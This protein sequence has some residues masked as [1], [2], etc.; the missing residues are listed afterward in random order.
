MI[1]AAALSSGRLTLLA[2]LTTAVSTLVIL[3]KTITCN[4]ALALTLT[5]VVL[6]IWQHNKLQGAIAAVIF[7]LVKAAFV[8]VAFAVDYAVV[9]RGGFD[10]L[11]VTP[12]ILLA[13]L[14]LWQ[15]YSDV[16]RDRLFLR[17][18]TRILMGLFCLIGALSIFNP[19]NLW[20]N[21][22]AGFERV[23]LPNMMVFFLFAS[24]VR[25]RGSWESIVKT[26]LILGLISCA[27]AV[28]QFSLGAYPWETDWLR[29]VAFRDNVQGVTVG[30]RG[31]ELRLF[32]IFFGY[33][34][35]TFTNVIIFA[36]ALACGGAWS[37]GWRRLRVVYILL[38]I[39]VLALSLERMPLL[40]SLI[41]S[42]AVLYLRSSGLKR[43]IMLVTTAAAALAIVVALNTAEPV[44]R[45]T[46][47][48]KFVRLAEMAN[49]LSVS[50]LR[51]RIDRNWMPT[52]E[53]VQSNP[54]GVGI[55]YGSQTLATESVKDGGIWMGPH[56]ELLQKALETGIP[57]AIVFVLLLA[58]ILRDGVRGLRG[59]NSGRYAA[60]M[61]ATTVAFWICG[62]VNLPFVGGAGMVYWALAGSLLAANGLRG[63]TPLR[64]NI[65][66]VA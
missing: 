6:T 63:N 12:A 51:D 16:A 20:F 45:D 47:L 52:L 42:V 31:I 10:L 48:S 59:K 41:A 27:Y 19:A 38:W 57:G 28:G 56:N 37:S 25:D 32:S 4:Q 22:L 33:M 3:T 21:G 9:G 1:R 11:G 64:A 13:V 8:R 44:L 17:G 61:I 7:Y 14:I 55:G 66:R 2:I 29:E 35:F 46:A 15:L 49:P 18:S 60:G 34:D 54:L 23:I 5:L 50:S 65:E 58:S 43:R 24:V 53:I 39:L 40:M 26:L 62:L 30:L 36:L